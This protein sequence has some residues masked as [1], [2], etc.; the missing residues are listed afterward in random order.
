MIFII[1][2]FVY[3]SF[4]NVLSKLR[5]IEIIDDVNIALLEMRK[6][7]KNYFLYQDVNAL[8]ELAKLGEERYEIIQSIQILCGPDFAR[9]RAGRIMTGLLDTLKEYLRIGQQRHQDQRSPP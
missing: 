2:L 3:L 5:S 1:G 8:K 4:N 9:A 7:E 6:A